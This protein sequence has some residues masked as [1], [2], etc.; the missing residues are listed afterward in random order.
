LSRLASGTNIWQDTNE[1]TEMFDSFKGFWS[2]FKNDEELANTIY[3]VLD[4]K[5]R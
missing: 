3:H 5:K 4:G 2:T 1:Y